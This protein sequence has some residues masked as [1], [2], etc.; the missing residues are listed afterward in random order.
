MAAS[1][2]PADEAAEPDRPAVRRDGAL[3]AALLPV[4]ALRL[5]ARFFVPLV[6]WFSA[7]SIVRYVLLQGISHLG[8]GRHPGARQ[9]AVLLPLSVAVL[10]S[11]VV[12]IGMLFTLGRG[13]SVIEDPDEPYVTA[14]GRTLFPFVL[15]YFGWN[16]YTTDLREVL[17]A[18]AQRRVNTGDV[19]N[20]GNVLDLP[21]AACLLVAAVSW[22]LR[23]LCERRYEEKHGRVMGIL[24]AFFEVNF[25]LYTLY[26]IMQSV[27]AAKRWLADRAFWHAITRIVPAPSPGPVKDALVLPLVWL[28]I[29]AIVY[30]LE[31]HDREAIRGTP[32]ERLPDRLE[33]RRRRLAEVASRSLRDKYVPIVH[34]LRLAHRAGAYVFAWFCLCYVAIGALLDPLQRGVVALIGT[35]HT[36]RFW[37]LVLVPIEFGHRMVGEILRLALLAAT[38]DLVRRRVSD[39]TPVADRPAPATDPDA[40]GA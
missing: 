3:G 7:G 30:G 12:T 15:V 21:I 18:D 33:G 40:G 36:V 11:L 31:M 4:S 10:A 6:M 29:A 5:A 27:M 38:F 22:L 35:D 23:V 26:S 13:L 1:A 28:A 25:T 16:L 2:A 14:V 24:T 17:R 8:S 39:G 9:V 37:N 19:M 20:V 32:L 34:A